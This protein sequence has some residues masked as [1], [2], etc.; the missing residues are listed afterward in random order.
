M[1]KICTKFTTVSEWENINYTRARL[2]SQQN[3]IKSPRVIALSGTFHSC[4]G[5]CMWTKLPLQCQLCGS[6]PQTYTAKNVQVVASLLT[7]CNNLLQ[8]ADIRMHSHGLR[9]L[10]KTSLLQVVN[11]LVA[12]CFNKLKQVCKWQVATS[13]QMTSCNKPDLNRLL[14]ALFFVVRQ[15][16]KKPTDL[17]MRYKKRYT[18]VKTHNLFRVDENSLEQCCA[19]HIVQC[20]Q[21]YCS[22]FLHLIAG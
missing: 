21:Q 12:T 20:C 13:L 3:C 1:L 6:K 8:Q 7:S 9:Q 16:M 17:Y 4:I 5:Y 2:V 11:R 19:A 15:T 10:V 14:Q 22:A 18:R